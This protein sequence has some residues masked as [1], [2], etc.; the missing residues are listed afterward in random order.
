MRLPITNGVPYSSMPLA[1]AKK[2]PAVRAGN[3]SGNN[4]RP[5]M[6]PGCAPLICPAQSSEA[7]TFSICVRTAK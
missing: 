1:K 4:I 7:G 6:R 5:T 2:P 3:V